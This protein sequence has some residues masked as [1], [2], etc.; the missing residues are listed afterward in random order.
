MKALNLHSAWFTGLG[1]CLC[2]HSAHAHL[3]SARFG[4][5]Y[6]GLLHPVISM[7]HLVPW[8]ALGL[9]AGLQ[10]PQQARQTL[11]VFPLAV[12]CG[13][14]LALLPGLNSLND[15]QWLLALNSGSFLL[16][17]MLLVFAVQL[18]RKFWL[19]LVVLGLAHGLANGLVGDSPYTK[20][21][22]ALGVTS[23]AYVLVTLTTTLGVTLKQQ[24]GWGVIALR[25]GGSWVFAI[26]LLFI[27]LTFFGLG[28][29]Q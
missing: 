22:F 13:T 15:A 29:A 9:L 11:L 10:Q 3:V 26:G 6:S 2:A 7:V 18:Q 20:F 14:A 1:L 8:L 17:G 5:Y 28:R 4:E 12:F 19:V 23:T 27:A 16:L 25:A 21:L 24:P